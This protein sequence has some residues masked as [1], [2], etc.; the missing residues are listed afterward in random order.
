MI[1][2]AR[3]KKGAYFDSVTLMKVARE[4][5]AIAG[6]VDAAAVMGTEENRRILAMSGL[7]APEFDAASGNDLL[8]AV[9]A[10]S[11]AVAAA[12]V[13]AAMELLE[14]TKKRIHA[15]ETPRP[16]SLDGA[17]QVL[18][19]ANL[20]LISVAGRYA[21]GLAQQA[22]ERGLHVMIFSDNVPLDTEVALKRFAVE[23]GLLV[24]GPDCGTAILNGVPLGFANVVSRG[25]I[26]IVAAAGTGLQEVSTIISNLGSGISQA[27]GTGG[28]DVKKAVGG[29]MFLEG[30][31][32]LAEDP[33][34]RVIVLVSKPP[35]EAVRARIEDAA[36]R[37][38]K[39]VVSVFLGG[40]TQGSC[41]TAQGPHEV[42]TL[43]AAARLAVSLARGGGVPDMHDALKREHVDH[44]AVARSLSGGIK[45]PRQY[46]RALMSGG[47]FAAEA[48]VVLRMAGV[49]GVSSNVPTAGAAPLKDPLRSTGHTVIDLGADEFTVGRPHPMIDYSLR[50]K[51]IAEEAR[52]PETAV[53]L[54][55]V[56][57]GYGSN[58]DPVLELADVI[59]G[60][61]KSV[62]VVCSVTG[63]DRDPTPRRV[64]VQ[65]LSDAGATVMGTNA[66]ASWVAAYI[67]RKLEQH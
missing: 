52:D 1:T 66:A 44:V 5:T 28:R 40:E 59:R 49:S 50:T 21:G 16:A 65:G 55:D 33:G 46:I 22:L 12:A 34:T 17:L 9:S 64:V 54:I 39:P 20:A 2:V 7:S 38:D 14:S 53:I 35:D 4:M 30:L 24:M 32:A 36:R 8:I 29:I 41:G 58:P 43:D 60:A 61:S 57:L 42:A 3:V 48:Q 15:E 51:R 47:T 10:E 63:T 56:V 37:I 67:A 27:I 23:R 6:V 18:P 31:T 62:A 11:E 19:G 26:G 13:A 45:A 25:P